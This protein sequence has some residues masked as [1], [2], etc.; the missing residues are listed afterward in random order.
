MKALLL[1]TATLMIVLGLAG[2]FW[3]EALMDLVKYSHT[4]SGTYVVA[5][6]RILIGTFLLTCAG[7]SR[8]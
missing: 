8:T 5:A 3:P 7:A 2:V 1:L 4:R 6:I